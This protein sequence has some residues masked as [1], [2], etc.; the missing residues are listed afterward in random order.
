MYNCL[1]LTVLCSYNWHRYIDWYET[2]GRKPYASTLGIYALPSFST[3][4]TYM[5]VR[6]WRLS[7]WSPALRPPLALAFQPLYI[8]YLPGY[9]YPWSF[10]C[11]WAWRTMHST[12]NTVSCRLTLAGFHPRSPRRIVLNWDVPWKRKLGQLHGHKSYY[13]LF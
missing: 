4:C 12:R 9:Y 11:G 1:S 13:F 10:S 3:R 5:Y 6:M 2:K 8:L 7:P